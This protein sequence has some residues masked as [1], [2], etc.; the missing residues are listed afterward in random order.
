MPRYADF[1]NIVFYNWRIL[2]RLRHRLLTIP[3]LSPS[4]FL[5]LP[6]ITFSS[7]FDPHI[8]ICILKSASAG[9]KRKG[10][11]FDSDPPPLPKADIRSKRRRR[12]RSEIKRKVIS[13]LRVRRRQ[14]KIQTSSSIS[15]PLPRDAGNIIGNI[16]RKWPLLNVRRTAVASVSTLSLFTWV[17]SPL[18]ALSEA[19]IS[20]SGGE[21]K[22]LKVSPLF[23]WRRA[24]SPLGRHRRRDLKDLA[25]HVEFQALGDRRLSAEQ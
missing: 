25:L 5:P 23:S 22:A 7:S 19:A 21:E 18:L 1:S 2:F 12:G 24:G 4:T 10:R 6:I 13:S 3:L 17:S 11:A 8:P 9:G 15:L 16:I 14:E 20:S